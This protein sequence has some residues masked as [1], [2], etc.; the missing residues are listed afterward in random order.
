MA[1]QG[2][3]IFSDLSIDN[4]GA[5]YTLEAGS[6]GRTPAVS[7][8]FN[9]TTSAPSA[10]AFT[11][12]PSNVLA[13]ASIA[14]PVEVTVLDSLGNRIQGDTSTVTISLGANPGGST[15]GGTLVVSAVDGVAT[16]PDLSLDQARAGYTL[17][18]SATGVASVSSAPFAV[19]PGVA[20]GFAFAVQPTST[21]AGM[22]IVPAVEVSVVDAFGNTVTTSSEAIDISIGTN[23]AGGI[24]NGTTTV[25]AVQGVAIFSDLSIE[26]AG[27]GYTLEA[28]NA[29]RTPVTSNSFDVTPGSPVAVKFLVQPSTTEDDDVITPAVEVGVMDSFGNLVDTATTSITMSIGSNPGASTLSGTTT[30]PAVNGVAVFPDLS[31]DNEGNAYRLAA[32]APG[33]VGAVSKPF[34]IK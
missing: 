27:R 24:L 23:P 25:V 31:L 20:V 16:F 7:N 11:V 18:A 21:E 5:G 30:Q 6:A 1:A 22:V 3:A 34:R 2:V 14:P 17:V 29:G 9:I 28:G 4:V 10:L 15:L 26:S 12:Q 13:G 19:S 32:D 8:P 33:L